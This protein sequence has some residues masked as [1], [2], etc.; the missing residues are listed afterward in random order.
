MPVRDHILCKPWSL[1]EIASLGRQGKRVME[2]LPREASVQRAVPD[3]IS[4]PTAYDVAGVFK[5]CRYDDGRHTTW[6][7]IPMH[8][9]DVVEGR[10]HLTREGQGLVFDVPSEEVEH[11]S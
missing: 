5:A 7:V 2:P 4:Q 1:P 8:H 10:V 11:V 6:F 3:S 9:I